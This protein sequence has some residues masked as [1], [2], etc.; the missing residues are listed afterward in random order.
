MGKIAA[1]KATVGENSGVR[2]EV[3]LYDN[4]KL[5]LLFQAIEMVRVGE[6]KNSSKKCCN[7]EQA[8]AVSFF[9]HAF[10]ELAEECRME[11]QHNGNNG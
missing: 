10:I 2:C 6:R 11:E 7:G 9:F 5:S 8:E 1:S 4:E 3:S